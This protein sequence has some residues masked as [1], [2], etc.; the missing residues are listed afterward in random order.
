[1]T[2]TPALDLVNVS[3]S[4]RFLQK[5]LDSAVDLILLRTHDMQRVWSGLFVV[6]AVCVSASTAFAGSITFSSS[7]AGIDGVTLNASALFT[8]TGNQLKITLRNAGDTS[9]TNADKSANTLTGV[10]FDL[11]NGIT[12]TPLS[13]TVAPGAIVQGNL[14][15]VGPCTSSTTN[16][17]GEFVF[18][19]GSWN[20]H[21][22][23]FGISSSGYIDAA[24]TGGNFNGPNLDD[25]NAPDGINF[26]IIADQTAANPFKPGSPNGNMAKNPLI[27]EQVV[28]TLTIAGG[29]LTETQISNVSFQYG[30]S[31]SEPKLPPGITTS[32]LPEPGLLALLAGGFLAAG[33]RRFTRK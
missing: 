33:R 14:C 19:T 30:T 9:G 8:I 3:V 11:P 2:T 10:F 21:A 20:G 24:A 27:E 15:D 29:T 7:G 28:F 13:A 16:V 25:P 6:L 12:L 18:R 26:G 4:R 32:Q 31:F 5:S 22:G 23:N 1:V 17:G